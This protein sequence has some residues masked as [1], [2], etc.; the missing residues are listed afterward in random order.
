MQIAHDQLLACRL[1]PKGKRHEDGDD[2]HQN[3]IG[4]G[5]QDF[6][7]EYNCESYDGHTSSMAPQT[8][9]AAGG[10]RHLIAK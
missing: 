2:R 6:S 9:Y 8:M 1:M 3:R 4:H 7:P 5:L 10:Q